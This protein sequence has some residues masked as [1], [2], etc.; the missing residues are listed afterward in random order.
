MPLEL[1]VAFR[2]LARSPGFLITAVVSLALGFGAAAAAFGVLDAVRFRAMP[3]PDADRLVVLSE[4]SADTRGPCRVACSVSYVTFANVLRSYP[5]H[6]LDALDAYTSGGKALNSGDEPRLVFGGIVTPHLFDLLGVRP[7]LGRSILPD[8]D[9][10]GVPLVV[11]LS[12]DLWTSQY[13]QDPAIVG[14]T[15]KLSD[16]F[17]TV[18]GIMPAGFN[19]EVGSQFWLPMTP[20]LDPST[21][22][23]IRSVTVIGRLA[24]GRSVEALRAELAAI[25]PAVLTP[26]GAAPADRIRL[27]AMPLRDRYTAS[28][29]S[30]DLIFAGVVACVLLIACAN[31]ANLALVRA[32]HQQKEFAVRTALGAQPARI[33]RAVF[34]QHLVVVLAAS[35]LGL[36]F[37]AWLL[38]TLQSLAILQSIRPSGMD[39]RLDARVLGFLALLALGVSVV[40]AFV[41]ARVA[42]RPGVQR[43]LREGAPSAGGSRRGSR[44]QRLFVVAQVAA[45]VV[46]MT[47]AGLLTRTAF[48]LARLDLGFDPR[49]VVQGT[50]SLP[51]P[52]RVREKYLPLTR[53]I[54]A[55]LRNLPGAMEVGVLAQLSLGL[56]GAAPGITVQGQSSEL[57]SELVPAGVSAVSPGYFRALGIQIVQGRDFT[58]QDL[59]SAPQVAIVNQWAARHWW[60]GQDPVGKSIRIDTAPSLSMTL[61]VAGVTRD[62]RAAQQNLLLADLGPEI[63]RPFEQAPSAFPTFYLR[64]AGNPAPL[65]RPVRQI[66]VRRV[67]DRPLFAS[68]L[69]EQVNDQLGA[70]RLNAVQIAA[71]A[72]IGFF[73][74]LTGIHGV[75]AYTVRRRTHEIGIRGALG[76]SR[77]GIVGMVLADG[78]RLTL[79]GLVVGIPSAMLA[80]GVI[81]GMLYGTSPTDPVVYGAVGLGVGAVSILAGYLPARRAAQVDPVIALREES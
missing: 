25:D 21:R 68:L 12:H 27:E 43:V 37:A 57:P 50:P 79:A 64:A 26:D 62:N 1:R 69:S 8:D 72:L 28:T 56:R 35:T 18:V 44:A 77:G 5:L 22:P 73:L 67:P 60:P 48:R 7:S 80:S 34:L 58:E 15:I 17:Y 38:H 19:H 55:E 31:V 36:G 46:L 9:R 75:L 6:T 13:A 74:A 45:A 30:H 23:S 32:L 54:V 20:T 42:I 2:S 78:A 66:L 81:R 10:L 53:E 24:P 11:L 63:Y 71:F 3:F 70:V 47:G 65:L 40:L 76:A 49:G 41:S 16:S 29:Q 51:H 33:A 14:R 4:V 59:E 52:W 39:Y 61:T